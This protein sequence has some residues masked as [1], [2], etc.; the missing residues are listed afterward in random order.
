MPVYLEWGHP[1]ECPNCKR[2]YT[3]DRV[4][5]Y[6]CWNIKC[7]KESEKNPRCSECLVK[8]IKSGNCLCCKK[9]LAECGE[10]S[11][12]EF[13]SKDSWLWLHKDSVKEEYNL[14][15]EELLE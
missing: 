6:R 4:K 8:M 15:G 12:E 1:Y 10:L 2:A 7:S 5:W 3:A 9:I 13:N 11:V 14:K